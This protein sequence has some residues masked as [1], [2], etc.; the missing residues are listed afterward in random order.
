MHGAFHATSEGC[1]SGRGS[2]V[3]DN[4]LVTAEDK[5]SPRIP[6]KT[7]TLPFLQKGNVDI[8][9]HVDEMDYSFKYHNASR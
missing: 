7:F 5:R 3:P 2:A 9:S 6:L 8:S 1:K 4:I